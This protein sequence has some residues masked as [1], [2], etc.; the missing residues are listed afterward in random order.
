VPANEVGGQQGAEPGVG[1]IAFSRRPDAIA[2]ARRIV[3]R[4]EHAAGRKQLLLTWMVTCC[5]PLGEV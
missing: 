3:L 2:R 4:G 5:A 1:A